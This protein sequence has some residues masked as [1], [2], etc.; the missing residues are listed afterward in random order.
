MRKLRIIVPAVVLLSAAAVAGAQGIKSLKALLTGYQ[1]VPAVSTAA[2]GELRARISNDDSEIAYELSYTDLEGDVQ[3]A[4]IHLGQK[5]VN[6]CI[7][8]WLCANPERLPTTAPIPPNTQR[9]PS[10]PATI[11]GTITAAN[12]VG[13]TAQGIEPGEF[14]E[15]VS[16]IRAGVTYVNVHTTRFPGGEIRSQIDPGKGE[17]GRGHK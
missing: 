13:P 5:G 2:D 16:A 15:L 11:T 8:V 4:H 14:G 9:C 7:S 3:Q 17:H 6:G 10:P 12:V 1:E